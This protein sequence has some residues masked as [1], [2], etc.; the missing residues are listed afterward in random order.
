[1]IILHED[2]DRHEFYLYGLGKEYLN[3][4]HTE[5]SFAK[6]FISP[7]KNG[8]I[9]DCTIDENGLILSNAR[10]HGFDGQLHT[11]GLTK[12]ANTIETPGIL[13]RHLRV[14]MIVQLARSA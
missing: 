6:T 8:D 9:E 11:K 7:W 13:G 2:S 3:F 5:C 4:Y 14:N 1:V 12:L 10:D